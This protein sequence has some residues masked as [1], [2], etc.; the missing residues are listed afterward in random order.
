MHK[1]II[2]W[3]L[4][5]LPFTVHAQTN[6]IVSTDENGQYFLN[7]NGASYFANL[8]LSCVRNDSIHFLQEIEEL[9]AKE[10]WPSFYGCYD[11]HSCVHNHWC[12][13]K[14]L[15][16]FPTL[17]EAEEIKQHLNQSFNKENIENEL[18]FFTTNEETRF[19]EFPYG[20]S[21]LLKVADELKNWDYPEA[22]IW[23][24]NL[25]PLL[26]FIEN[27]HIEFWR[28]Q[29]PEKFISGSHDSPSMGLSFAYDYA[30]SF[31]KTKLKKVIKKTASK[32]Y[33]KNGY[34]P[35]A[36]EPIEYDFMSGGLLTADLMRKVLPQDKLVKWLNTFSP[37][38]LDP[39][40]ISSA[41]VIKKTEKHD[42]YEAHW[43]GYHLNRIWCLN[44]LL[45]SLDDQALS[46]ELRKK[47]ISEMN[48]M[49]DYSQKSIGIGIYD[50]DHWLSSFS[51]FALMGY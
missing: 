17:P 26:V 3:I 18:F 31:E 12:L 6:S 25:E 7:E 35:L 5:F 16:E 37:E 15:K 19:Y 28:K 27:N 10:I 47:W 14:L 42:G 9:K 13:I 44:G 22:K 29:K 36:Q 40:K 38:I 43:D 49:W 21:W 32:Y 8:S 2:Y 41:L 24:D 51:V 1:N 46:P 20:Q 4:C 30:V 48:S 34:Y 23:L 39:Q 50:I 45:R 33:L 11:W